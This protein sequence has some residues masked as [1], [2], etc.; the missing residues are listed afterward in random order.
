MTTHKPRQFGGGGGCRKGRP[1]NENDVFEM[2][3]NEVLGDKIRADDETASAMWGALVIVDW[4]HENGDTAS[5]SFRAAGDMIA[6]IR[7]EGGEMPYMRWYCSAPQGFVR[8]DIAEALAQKGWTYT[9]EPEPAIPAPSYTPEQQKFLN[10]LYGIEGPPADA[11]SSE[12]NV[13]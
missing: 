4:V 2:T 5:Y 8:D 12:Q 10:A 3:V 6:A 9:M 13:P 7:G 1:I 11:Q